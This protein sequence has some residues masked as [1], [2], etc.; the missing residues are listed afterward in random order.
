MS[1]KAVGP[2]TLIKAEG[3]LLVLWTLCPLVGGGEAPTAP[4]LP[5]G[6]SFGLVSICFTAVGV[7][8]LGACIFVN[9][10]SSCWA[11]LSV[12]L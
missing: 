8:G 11:D 2:S 3:P 12:A 4:V 7:T 5:P 1:A 9:V 6:S 10:L